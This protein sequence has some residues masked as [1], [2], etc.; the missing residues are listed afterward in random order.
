MPQLILRGRI[1]GTVNG[2]LFDKDGTLIN[3]ENRL[4]QL[5]QFRI[6][7]AIRIYKEKSG[8]EIDLKRLDRLLRLSYG[9]K[10]DQIDPNGSIAIA[11]RK[12]NLIS[13][14][15]IFSILGEAWPE[16]IKLSNKVFISADY[17]LRN[18]TPRKE[19]DELLPGVE[20]LLE[21]LRKSKLKAGIISNDSNKGIKSF[22]QKYSLEKYFHSFWSSDDF[23]SKPDPNA[24]RELCNQMKV[25]TSECALVG[26]AETDLLMAR[27]SNIKIVFGY[28]S[29]WSIKPA[30]YE[31][32]HLIHDWDDLSIQ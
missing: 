32:D 8:K 2:I 12:D 25:K 24:V 16:S 4:L 10:N 23:P 9:L 11:S 29:G 20:R 28:T 17:L 30:L 5:A 22:I 26:D 1:I 18:Q 15:T 27:E 3:S 31:Y 14:A 19:K 13:T 7:E 21:Y 6:K